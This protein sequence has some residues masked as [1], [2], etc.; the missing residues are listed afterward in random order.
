[1]NHPYSGKEAAFAT[2]HKKEEIAAPVFAE[3]HVSLRVPPNINT[4]EFGTFTGETKRKQTPLETARLKARLGMKQLGLP[5]GLASEGSFGPC[6]YFPF[7]GE[8]CEIFLW[9]DEILGIEIHE[10]VISTSTNFSSAAVPSLEKAE[11][12]LTQA[13]FPSHSLIVRPNQLTEPVFYKGIC[14]KREL[15]EAIAA[16]TAISKDGLALIQTDMRAHHNPMRQKVIQEAARKLVKRMGSLCPQCGCP[17]W[18]VSKTVRG[19]PCELC[20]FPTAMVKEEIFSCKG[21]TYTRMTERS[22]GKKKAGAM[23]CDSCNP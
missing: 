4:D 23:Y 5:Y 8:D 9:M 22:D 1:M 14:R 11:F 7:V 10:Q 3:L 13:S 18:G 12:F 21:C 17:G 16:C 20:H 15:E 19:L 2:M 6:R